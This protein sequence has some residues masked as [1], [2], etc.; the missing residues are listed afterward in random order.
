MMHYSWLWDDLKK[1]VFS[2]DLNVERVSASWGMVGVCEGY[3]CV[4]QLP[5][6]E[7]SGKE[8]ASHE[9]LSD[10]PRLGS[11][12]ASRRA[13]LLLFQ[14]GEWRTMVEECGVV[15]TKRLFSEQHKLKALL[16]Y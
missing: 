7:N 16:M 13:I 8:Y 3:M 4:T 1:N 9:A 6:N 5:P 15:C 11:D 2:L 10:S 14:Q 12:N